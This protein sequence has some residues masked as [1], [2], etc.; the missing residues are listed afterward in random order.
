MGG[1]PW[2]PPAASRRVIAWGETCLRPSG[3]RTSRT[4]P[5]LIW[6]VVSFSGTTTTRLR[7]APVGTFKPI[8]SVSCDMA[9]NVAEWTSDYYEIP[10]AAAAT[11]P[12]RSGQR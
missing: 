12:T 7:A 4:A 5:L 6:S 10:P 1:A 3:S 8:S 2:R 9:G 11:D